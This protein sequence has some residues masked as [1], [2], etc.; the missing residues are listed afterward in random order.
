MASRATALG[1]GHAGGALPVP[2]GVRPS[3][4]ASGE[5][6]PRRGRAQLPQNRIDRAART[7][8]C[9]VGPDHSLAGRHGGLGDDMVR[10]GRRAQREAHAVDGPGV[11]RREV[12]QLVKRVAERDGVHLAGDFHMH[13]RLA[14]P[15][16]RQAA[17]ASR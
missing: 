15:G 13:T 1:S 14:H 17:E 16:R 6:G 4:G 10:V 3:A 12:A 7:A 2:R 9:P 8:G 5:R 11:V